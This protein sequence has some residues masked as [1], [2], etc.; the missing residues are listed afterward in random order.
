MLK[1]L[2]LLLLLFVINALE[3][4]LLNYVSLDFLKLDFAIPL[5]VYQSFFGSVNSAFWVAIILGLIQEGFSSVSSG[6]LVF[7]KTSVFLFCFFLR[8]RYYIE[9]QYT[10]GAVCGASE[11]FESLLVLALS[12]LVKGDISNVFNIL[13]YLL[14]NTVLTALFSLPFYYVFIRIDQKYGERQ[15]E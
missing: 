4:V 7:T 5:I 2:L 15:W 3:S 6:T 13:T 14:P 9:S 11:L 8:H 12:L 1:L 10:F